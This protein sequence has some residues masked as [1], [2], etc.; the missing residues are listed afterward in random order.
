MTI[1]THGKKGFDC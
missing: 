1:D